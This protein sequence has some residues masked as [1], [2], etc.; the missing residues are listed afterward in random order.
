V[1]EHTQ[2]RIILQAIKER[3]IMND[4]IAIDATYFEA[5]NQEP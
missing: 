4:M 2:E 1:L 3:L 5:S